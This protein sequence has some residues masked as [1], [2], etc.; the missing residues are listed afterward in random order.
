M[1][2][3]VKRFKKGFTLTELIVVIVI[4]NGL[5]EYLHFFTSFIKKRGAGAPLFRKYT[6]DYLH[7]N[8]L[9]RV[10]QGVFHTKSEF[11]LPLVT[12]GLHGYIFGPSRRRKCW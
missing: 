10:L 5:F 7:Y 8:T 9:L 11:F 12:W 1:N 4:I 6:L 2:R 3:S